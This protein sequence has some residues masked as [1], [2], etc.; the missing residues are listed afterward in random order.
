MLRKL[1]LLAIDETPTENTVSQNIIPLDKPAENAQGASENTTSPD[2][3][4]EQPSPE[5][6]L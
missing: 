5:E 4:K 2:T 3:S 1:P 6:Q